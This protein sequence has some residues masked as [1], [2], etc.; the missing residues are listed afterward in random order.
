MTVWSM[1]TR[2]T[3]MLDDNVSKKLRVLQAKRLKGSSKSISFSTVLND[4]LRK[5]LWTIQLER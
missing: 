2:I 3:I 4:T 5:G 1:A